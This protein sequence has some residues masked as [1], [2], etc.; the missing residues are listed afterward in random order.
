MEIRTV[1][2]AFP[3]T[4]YEVEFKTE[5]E[6]RNYEQTMCVQMWDEKGNLTLNGEEAMFVK[7]GEG[8]MEL[9]FEKYGKDNFPGL[10]EDDYG[11]FYWDDWDEIFHHLDKG[12]MERVQH[13]MDEHE[14]AYR[15]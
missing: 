8:M 7:V 11:Y 12:T 9:L 13:F 6:C 14:V 2:V 4:D 10:C 3:G 5:D 15:S 1:Y